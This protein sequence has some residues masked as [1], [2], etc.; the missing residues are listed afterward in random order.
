MPNEN[1]ILFLDR[2]RIMEAKIGAPARTFYV[3]AAAFS[4]LTLAS[5]SRR[6]LASVQD[7]QNE[8]W[9]IPLG[10]K[11]L[12]AIGNPQR[13]LQSSAGDAQPRFSPDGRSL[14]FSSKRSGTS[15]VWVAGSDGR[16][17]KQLT[18]S[19][20]YIAGYLRWS[21]D[22]QFLAFHGR[23]PK[24]P[25]IYFVRVTDGL[26]KQVTDGKPGF[27]APSWSMDGRSL[28]GS[29]LEDG[30]DRTYT[31]PVTGGPPQYLFEGSHAVEA[32]GRRLLIYD[33]Q[34]RSGIYAR[35]L[36]GDVANNP[37]HLLVADFQPPWGGFYPVDDGIYYVGSTWTGLPRAFRF[38]SIDTGKVI[39]VAPSP[40][41][42]DLGLTVTPDR[43]VLAYTTKPQNSEDLVEIEFN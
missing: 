16:H 21:P 43:S 36:Q 10:D 27:R 7:R 25:Q 1:K 40:T 28:Y 15:E 17:P 11:G 6:L 20:F 41:N 29:V 19:S 34:D 35:S 33:K 32:P 9:T 18:H 39:D 8:I 4:E 37:E 3:S 12:K 14:A 38:Y 26:V 13:I 23:L 31:V 2:S 22:G 5:A 30:R 24:D 42:L